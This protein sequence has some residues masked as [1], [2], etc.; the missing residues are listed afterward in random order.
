ML[1]LNNGSFRFLISTAYTC[2]LHPLIQKL[3]S[4]DS[5]FRKFSLVLIFDSDVLESVE[6]VGLNALDL[7][8]FIFETLTHLPSFFEVVQA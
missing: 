8:S 6:L 7:K 4:V 1:A 5:L 2:L 3:C